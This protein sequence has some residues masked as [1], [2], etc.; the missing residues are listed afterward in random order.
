MTSFSS[1]KKEVTA[2]TIYNEV[3]MLRSSSS[4]AFLLVEGSSDSNVFQ[5]F[6]SAVDCTIVVCLGKA[7]LFGAITKLEVNR[8]EGVLAFADRDFSDLIGYPEYN[9]VVVFTDDNDL[10]AQILNSPATS[11]VLNE[12]GSAKKIASVIGE[13]LDNA[14]EAIASWSA[15]IGALRLA[16]MLKGWGLLFAEMTYQFASSNSPEICPKKTV[17]HV[18]SRSSNVAGP[19]EPQADAAIKEYLEGYPAWDL[20]HGHDCI[21]VLARSLRHKLGNTNVFNSNSGPV[22]L[23]KILRLSYEIEM[24]R[25]TCCYKHI[26][27][28]EKMTGFIVLED[29]RNAVDAAAA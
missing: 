26:R 20:A 12:F 23:E 5:R 19:T 21:A 17:R 15:P 22:A 10:E 4:K 14:H 9:G 25:T 29:T 28:W 7:N 6:S 18:L 8:V 1:V 2:D 11:K 24:F 13:T 27:F 16:N 3:R